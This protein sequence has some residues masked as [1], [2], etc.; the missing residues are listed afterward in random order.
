VT[1]GSVVNSAN[2]GPLSQGA[3]ELLGLPGELFMRGLKCMVRAH[4][5]FSRR[6]SCCLALAR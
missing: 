6:R 3:R 2:G 5:P 4:A 1:L